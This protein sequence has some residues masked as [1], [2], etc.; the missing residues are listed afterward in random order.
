MRDY[1]ITTTLTSD[2]DT[3]IHGALTTAIAEYKARIAKA[4]E[5]Q[6][7]DAEKYWQRLLNE[8][9]EVMVHL[10]NAPHEWKEAN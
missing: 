6:C 9:V 3:A 7:V 2:Q 8:A 1:T 4:Q 5:Q 10:E